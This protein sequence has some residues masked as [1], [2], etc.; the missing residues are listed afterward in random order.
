MR[1]L[2]WTVVLISLAFTSAFSE[3]KYSGIDG[4]KIRGFT[5]YNN[6]TAADVDSVKK[7]GGNT[8]RIMLM[9]HD[10]YDLGGYDT[11]PN[12]TI[13]PAKLQNLVRVVDLCRERGMLAIIDYHETPGLVRFSGW[14]DFRI[15][16]N[17]I[18]GKRFRELFISGWKQLVFKF[19][20][21]P[22]ENVAFELFN[23]PEPKGNDWNAPETQGFVWD[24]SQ[25]RLIRGI[26]K[27]DKVHTIIAA[28]P[29]G[30]R[31]SA[32]SPK[33]YALG[34]E[35]KTDYPGWNPSSEIVNDGKVMLTVH[36]YHPHD[37][38]IQWGPW[39]DKTAK[40]KGYPGEFTG[41]VWEKAQWNKERL[42]WSL[43]PIVFFK[44][45]YPNIPVVITEFSAI[46]VAP[47]A[48]QY[49]ADVI[50]LFKEIGLGWTYHTYKERAYLAT[51]K[52]ADDTMWELELSEIPN[53]GREPV[54]KD[55]LDRFKAVVAGFKN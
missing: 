10:L 55:P 15:W 11:C 23:E 28:P 17:N 48:A 51:K 49:L 16:E 36:M 29:Y 18:V 44:S 21:Y 41:D 31:I 35:K 2:V 12:P 7:W 34:A 8:L 13:N 6:V 22:A 43:Q 9:I 33:P 25:S 53:D 20:D 52:G 50:S 54:T 3:V 32:I 24:S 46:R 1:F 5:C 45:V 4:S 38:T 26:R 39:L 40:A 37:Y 27:V 14:K 30:W 47:G 42:R 19:K